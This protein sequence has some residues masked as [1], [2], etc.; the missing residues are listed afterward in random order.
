MNIAAKPFVPQPSIIQRPGI[1]T[2]P[3]DL[4][5]YVVSPGGSVIVE[6]EGGD[7]ITVLDVEGL[8]PCELVTAASN[9]RI[10]ATL[11][12]R[13]P[14]ADADGFVHRWLRFF[15]EGRNLHNP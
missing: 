10:D 15:F 4:E 3:D 13:K 1:L 6:I 9:G 8:Q 5:R 2:L 7:T 11:L 12:D 14:D